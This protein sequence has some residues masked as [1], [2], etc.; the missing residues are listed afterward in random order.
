MDL[1]LLGYFV[2]V[3]DNG[4]ITKAAEALYISQPSLSQSIRMLE[5]ELGAPLFNRAGR[6]LELTPAGAAM[7]APARRVLREA[8]RARDKVAAIRDLHSGRLTVAAGAAVTVDPLPELVAA[9][10]RAHPGIQVH[11][12]DP[13]S[14][15]Q[16]VNAVRRGWAEIGLTQLPVKAEALTVE[17]FR[18]ERIVLAV[19]PDQAVKLPDPIPFDQIRELSLVL[20]ADDRLTGVLLDRGF[21]DAV[22]RVAIRCAHA[23]AVW[24]LVE[25]GAGAT[26]MPEPLVR[27]VLAHVVVR[28]TEP[29]IRRSLGLVYRAGQLS[30]AGRAFVAIA[31]ALGDAER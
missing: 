10:R 21:D 20:E 7:L 31:A 5:R 16:V 15:A 14:P 4:G 2:A 23:Q 25:Q 11:V 30:P 8:V 3:V 1:R 26:L 29:E 12:Q 27:Q 18:T 19:A 28:A 24:E 22:G 6:Q 17:P 9:L 13:G